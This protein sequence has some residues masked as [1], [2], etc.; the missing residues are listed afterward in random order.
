MNKKEEI[1]WEE[2]KKEV[3]NAYPSLSSMT[4]DLY[5][6]DAKHQEILD[7]NKEYDNLIKAVKEENKEDTL[8]ELAKLYDYIPKFKEACSNE[9]SQI[10]IAN[11]KNYL[12]KAYSILDKEDWA[13]IASNINH[14]TQEFTKLVTNVENKNNKQYNINKAYIMINEMQN[15]VTLQDKEVFLIKYKNLLEELENI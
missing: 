2:I 11:T 14:S 4:L 9:S 10:I 7:F 13:T 3:E 5:K 15:S 6:T 8:A 1:N 12:F